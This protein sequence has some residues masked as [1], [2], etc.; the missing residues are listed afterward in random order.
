VRLEGDRARFPAGETGKKIVGRR[1]RR[2][3]R[4]GFRRRRSWR[5]SWSCICD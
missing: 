1:R 5:R 4:R 3:R 2:R